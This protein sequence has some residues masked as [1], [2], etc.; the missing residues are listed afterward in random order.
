MRTLFHARMGLRLHGGEVTDA[1]TIES[2]SLRAHLTPSEH[3][4]TRHALLV[5]LRENP[6]EG[7]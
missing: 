1:T 2:V 4:K 7:N 3:R 5:F 6:A